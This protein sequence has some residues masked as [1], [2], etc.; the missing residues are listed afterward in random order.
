MLLDAG[1]LQDGEPY[2]AGTAHP[3]VARL[4]TATAG[5]IDA[6]EGDLVTVSTDRGEITL[7]LA[8]T[9]MPDRVVWLPLNSAG[10]AVHQQL[11][12]TPGAIVSIRRAVQ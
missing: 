12:V 8:I 2:L 3:P 6:A 5:E 11:A 7:P 9:E 1:R 4:S 10:S